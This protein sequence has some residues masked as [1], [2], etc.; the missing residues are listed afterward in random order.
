MMGDA[1]LNDKIEKPVGRRFPAGAELSRDGISFRVWA[2]ERT[3]VAVV[4]NGVEHELALDR[5]VIFMA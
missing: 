5:D 2:P 3:T 4:V 1:R